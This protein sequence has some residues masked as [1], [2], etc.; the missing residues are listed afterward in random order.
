MLSC[1]CRWTLVRSGTVPQPLQLGEFRKTLQ[2]VSM[3]TPGA[4]TSIARTRTAI[5][6]T[7]TSSTQR[8]HTIATSR[9][10]VFTHPCPTCPTPEHQHPSHTT[11]SRWCAYAGSCAA[12]LAAIQVRP[13]DA[14]MQSSETTSE[15]APSAT[16]RECVPNEAFGDAIRDALQHSKLKRPEQTQTLSTIQCHVPNLVTKERNV[17]N[18]GNHPPEQ[19]QAGTETTTTTRSTRQRENGMSLFPA[20]VDLGRRAA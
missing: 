8:I 18:I 13:A 19:H 17:C 2:S 7:A 4:A 5:H 3:T 12:I 9:S 10:N 1:L 16:T 14:V 15:C 6:L 11:Y 20:N